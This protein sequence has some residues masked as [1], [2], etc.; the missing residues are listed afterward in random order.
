MD[1]WENTASIQKSDA[2]YMLDTGA[3]TMGACHRQWTVDVL[4]TVI[5]DVDL[6]AC[7]RWWLEA[8]YY[9][10][11]YYYYYWGPVWPRIPIVV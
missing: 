9:S 11:Y 5:V 10:Y 6:V 1:G 4:Y 2:V 7:T 8:W 3:K